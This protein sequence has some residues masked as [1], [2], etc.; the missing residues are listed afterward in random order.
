MVMVWRA[1]D[2]VSFRRATRRRQR[3]GGERARKHDQ[4]GRGREPIRDGPFPH[5]QAGNK[6]RREAVVVHLDVLAEP[7]RRVRGGLARRGR[8]VAA[9]N[10]GGILKERVAA[11]GLLWR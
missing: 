1:N 7:V 3:D 2:E 4:L 8:V 6:R 10:T 9:R 5:L 11:V